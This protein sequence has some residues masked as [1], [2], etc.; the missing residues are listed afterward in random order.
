[1]RT[2]EETKAY[3]EGDRFAV[4]NGAEILEAK[5]GMA[6]C[7]ME[8]TSHH[9]NAR[10]TVMGGAIFTLADFTFAVAANTEEA[11]CV[12]LTSE[13]HYLAPATGSYLKAQAEPIKDGRSVCHYRV[14]VWDDKEKKVAELTVCGFKIEGEKP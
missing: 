9:R 6:L 3:F 14:L 8:I 7:R 13:I 5:D 10:G 4:E 2:L 12:T 11:A 1:M